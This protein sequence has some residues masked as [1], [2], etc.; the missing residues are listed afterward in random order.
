MTFLL[1]F[2]NLHFR[3]KPETGS[4]VLAKQE[5]GLD[6]NTFQLEAGVGIVLPLSRIFLSFLLMVP[7][8]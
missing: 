8:C 5:K 7:T 1:V 4:S 2:G 6:Y 3:S